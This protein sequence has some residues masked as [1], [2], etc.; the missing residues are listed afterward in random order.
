IRTYL[1]EDNLNQDTTSV[2]DQ[3]LYRI[4]NDLFNVGADLATPKEARWNGMVLVNQDSIVRLE[5]AIDRL[6]EDLP[7][8]RE[9]ILPGGG[10]VGA[11]FHQARTVCRRAERR[12][13]ELM[14]QEP[15]VDSTAMTYLNRLSDYLF[16]AGRWAAK[17]LGENEY[18]WQRDPKPPKV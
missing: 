16:V 18:F 13:V 10:K 1:A 12:V 14:N 5:E 7:P 8:L 3:V 17:S 9:F 11:F 2:L 4:Q 6:N 15:E